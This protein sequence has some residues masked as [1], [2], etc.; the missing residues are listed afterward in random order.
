[1]WVVYAFG[2]AFF[3]G[4][5]AILA[6]SGV[7]TTPSSLATALLAV[8]AVLALANSRRETKPVAV[9]AENSVDSQPSRRGA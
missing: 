7:T 9:S 5:T 6:K 8:G 3:A 2:S 1:M 4:L